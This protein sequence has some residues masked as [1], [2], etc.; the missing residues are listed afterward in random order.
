MTDRLLKRK[1]SVAAQRWNVIQAAEQSCQIVG[2]AG[3]YPD[4]RVGQAYIDR[5][6]PV[7]E[8]RLLDAGIGLAGL[9]N[10]TLR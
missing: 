8:Q 9:L 3:F 5:F 10:D 7:L 6:T 2:M 1:A 4:R